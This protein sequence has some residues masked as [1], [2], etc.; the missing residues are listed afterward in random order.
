[1]RQFRLR[2]C[3]WRHDGCHHGSRVAQ[4]DF[5]ASVRAQIIGNALPT[6]NSHPIHLS[7]AP[8]KQKVS[9]SKP[10]RL[11]MPEIFRGTAL[12]FPRNRTYRQSNQ[13]DLLPDRLAK[14]NFSPCHM[15]CACGAC[16][17]GASFE[18]DFFLPRRSAVLIVVSDQE[19][20]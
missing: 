6:P 15:V 9:K 2:S 12:R 5:G 8:S 20:A 10:W 11:S 14:C 13:H 17:A 4:V 18:E 3:A 19:G 7:G 16:M 1:M